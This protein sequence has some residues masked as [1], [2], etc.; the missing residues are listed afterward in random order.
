M[1]SSNK[2]HSSSGEVIAL[3]DCDSYYANCEKIFQP[4]LKNKAVVVLSNNDGVVV[5]R[6]RM[7]KRL[8]IP[9]GAALFQWQEFFLQHSVVALS[10]NYELYGS[11]SNRVM[12]VL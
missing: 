12:T 8:G 1:G 5:A 2:H 7:A 10:S 9:M 3:A 11:I 4:A 6:D